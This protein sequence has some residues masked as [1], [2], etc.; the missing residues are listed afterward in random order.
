[1]RE[2]ITSLFSPL[3]IFW[4]LVLAAV[5]FFL[6][7][8]RKTAKILVL[9]S[10]LWLLLVSTSFLPGSICR[11]LE[12][13]YEVPA[14][15]LPVD[16][17]TGINILVLGAGVSDDP[18][19][20]ATDKLSPRLLSR[21]AE[22]IS[23]YRKFSGSTLITSGAKFRLNTDLA[24]LTAQAAIS[25]G[26]NP[27]D[28]LTMPSTVN[29]RNEAKTYNLNFGNT[30]K[31]ILVTDALHMPRAMRLFEE[32]GLHPIPWPTNHMIK[33]NINRNPLKYLPSEDNIRIMDA[34]M[35]EYGGFLESS[36]HRMFHKN[37][38]KNN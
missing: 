3:P 16:D 5:V 27:T 17:S 36:I 29:T 33:R 23:L 9:S 19:L 38:E 31:L 18:L 26:V 4:I 28:I 10:F 21:L 32:Y 13:K 25:L 15:F 6:V 2:L 22:G 30:Q 12:S 24:T 20:S 35:H 7:K 14:G 37:K 8:K 34:V 1:M 11:G